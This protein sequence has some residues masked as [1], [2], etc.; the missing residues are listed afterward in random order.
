MQIFT[1]LYIVISLIVLSL[2]LWKFKFSY[3]TKTIII[4]IY[5][6]VII[7]ILHP[8]FLV[9]LLAIVA[10]IYYMLILVNGEKLSMKSFMIV[11]FVLIALVL[12]TGKYGPSIIDS[13]FGSKSVLG[14]NILV[15]IGVSYFAMKIIQLIIN[16][17]RGLLKEID[18]IDV[19]SFLVFLPTFAAGPIESY[20]SFKQANIDEFSKDDYFYGIRRIL[21]GYFKKFV[22]T[23]VIISHY[24]LNSLNNSFA[25][26]IPELQVLK[27]AAV[28]I[29]SFLIAYFDLSSYSDIA[30]GFSRL[31]GFK[32]T[33]NFNRPF[34]KRNIGEFWRS[35]HM[36]LS[37]WC[38]SNVYFPVFGATRKVWL[39][40]Y[41]SMIVMGMW[42]FVSLK[43]L[44]W[45]LHHATAL[46]L[47]NIFTNYK[48]KHKKLKNFSNTKV[49]TFLSYILTFWFV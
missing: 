48:R 28:V 4:S 45:A 11:G 32:I 24:L 27:P 35:W 44:A 15:P 46:V 34:W 37:R 42:H 36:S 12:V 22:I 39:G 14:F 5:S 8:I 40:M 6:L 23:D 21:I 41:A 43:W 7:G 31:L 25:Y 29:I 18:F 17:R 10:L 9:I 2:I 38:T 16:F 1:E 3:R 30:I 20:N 49:V 26:F 47:F 33:E 13:I 19:V